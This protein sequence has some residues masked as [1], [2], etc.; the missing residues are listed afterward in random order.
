[1]LGRFRE[2][3]MSG[4]RDATVPRQSRYHIQNWPEAHL[5]ERFLQV[6]CTARQ[7]R[8][9]LRRRFFLDRHSQKWKGPH[10]SVDEYTVGNLGTC[11]YMYPLTSNATTPWTWPVR[12]IAVCWTARV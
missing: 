4:Y 9:S 6:R 1:M 3:V 7:V 5:W 10:V 2:Q 11:R 8:T 12:A